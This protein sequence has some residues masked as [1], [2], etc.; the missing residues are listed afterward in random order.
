MNKLPAVQRVTLNRL[1]GLIRRLYG[2]TE[3]FLERP[4]DPQLWYNRGYANGMV[5]A[6]VAMGYGLYL[7]AEISIDPSNVIQ[8][9]EPLPWGQ[10]YRH[11][12]EM[13]GR[14]TREVLASLIADD[15]QSVWH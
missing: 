7:E 11:G 14:E 10:A 3:G 13:G 12:V 8:K 4:D 2:E 5:Q 6:L 15:D 9:H 1:L